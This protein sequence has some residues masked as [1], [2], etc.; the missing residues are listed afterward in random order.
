MRIG[1]SAD[2]V[3]VA[4]AT[5]DLLAR[6]AHGRADDLLTNVLLTA[7]C[8]V[9]FAPAM[10]TEMWEHAATQAN[11]ATLRERGALVIEPAVGRLTGADTGKGRLPEP[12]E[13]FADLPGRPGPRRRRG[14]TWPAAP[15]SSPRA[16]P[17]SRSTRCAS[18]AT[19]PRAARASRWPAPRPPAVPR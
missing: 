5:A 3:V 8:P 12:D 16:A 11:V 13:I 19:V 9:V 14:P 6:A 2:L 1:Q 4:P 7:R 18:S 10:H 15:S 17:A